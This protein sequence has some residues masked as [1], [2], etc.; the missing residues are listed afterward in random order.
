MPCGYQRLN[1]GVRLL[2]SAWGIL[3]VE[4]ATSIESFGQFTVEKNSQIACIACTTDTHAHTSISVL[5]PI[6][7]PFVRRS[8]AFLQVVKI[9][10]YLLRVVQWQ[11]FFGSKIKVVY[12]LLGLSHCSASN[13]LTV[14]WIYIFRNKMRNMNKEF[15]IKK[16]KSQFGSLFKT[17]ESLFS[18]NYE[19][20]V[21]KFRIKQKDAM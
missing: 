18:S 21:N 17:R 3:T 6:A 5:S 8:T 14:S 10:L 12:T 15:I 20:N 7:I 4:L 11:R 16:I 19:G 2:Q 1:F 9:F 13:P